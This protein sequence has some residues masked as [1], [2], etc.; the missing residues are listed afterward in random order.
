MKSSLGLISKTIKM[1]QGNTG[2]SSL[3]LISGGGFMH[4]GDSKM[5]KIF[6]MSQLKKS[7]LDSKVSNGAEL[8]QHILSL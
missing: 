3:S 5:S 8:I 2:G 7:A 4:G 6:S 1:S